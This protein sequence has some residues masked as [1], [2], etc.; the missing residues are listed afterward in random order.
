MATAAEIQSLRR[1]LSLTVE[2]MPDYVINDLFTEAAISYTGTRSK[3]AYVRVLALQGMLSAAA[4][5]VDYKQDTTTES[6][7]QYFANLSKLLAHWQDQLDR[8]VV[9]ETGSGAAFA[10]TTVRVPVVSTW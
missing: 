8:A 4:T 7:S 1:D 3:P 5:Q 9:I 2:A 6:A 10:G